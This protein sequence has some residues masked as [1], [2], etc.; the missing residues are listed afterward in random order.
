[1]ALEKGELVETGFMIQ[2]S[3]PCLVH[4][5]VLI[6]I[7]GHASREHGDAPHC[8]QDGGPPG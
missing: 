5:I 8:V 4:V 7:H 1:M 2:N 6:E 3:S